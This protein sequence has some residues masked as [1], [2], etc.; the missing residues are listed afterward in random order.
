MGVQI[1]ISVLTSAPSKGMRDSKDIAEFYLAAG[2]PLY[3][4]CMSRRRF[5]ALTSCPRANFA[6]SV[7]AHLMNSWGKPRDHLSPQALWYALATNNF[8]FLK[9]QPIRLYNGQQIDIS[10]LQVRLQQSAS[11][12]CRCLTDLLR[13]IL[14]SNRLWVVKW[15]YKE[16]LFKEI[17]A[18]TLLW[19]EL[20]MTREKHVWGCLIATYDAWITN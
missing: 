14:L 5:L 17:S 4:Q 8:P 20:Q 9:L 13:A 18:F 7:M 16:M 10:Y 2:L 1:G 11:S 6:V 12:L 3:G 15:K 19:G